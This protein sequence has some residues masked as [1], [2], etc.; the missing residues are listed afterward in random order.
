MY[1]L[2]STHTNPV[3]AHIVRGRLEAEGLVCAVLFEHHIWAK[4]SLSVAL[5]GVRLVVPSNSASDAHEVMR[6]I[7][8]GEYER[9]LIEEQGLSKLPCPKC[10]STNTAPHIWPWK[11]A[12]A[13]IFTVSLPIPYTSHLHSCDDCMH[14]WVAHE[15]RPYPLL[16]ILSYILLTTFV[17]CLLYLLSG[18]IF[19]WRVPWV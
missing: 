17:F 18:H 19:S 5:G 8:S 11:L 13:F 6:K 7:N 2:V 14:S 16:T 1:S 3:E 9:L 4:W 12:L 10:G 15:Q